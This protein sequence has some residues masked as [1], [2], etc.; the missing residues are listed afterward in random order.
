MIPTIS[1]SLL[2]LATSLGLM[3]LHWRTWRTL[4]DLPLSEEDTEFSWRQF[5]RRMQTSAMIGI[6]GLAIF[7][8]LWVQPTL[9][10]VFYWL[11]VIL[12]VGWV[13]LLAVADIVSTR[14][15]YSRLHRQQLAEQ[16]GLRNKLRHLQRSETNGSPQRNREDR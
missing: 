7:A 11:G 1:F 4:R 12:L 14:L 16:S 2:L 3:W 15:H 8:G 6:V 5:R 9:W 10:I 13:G